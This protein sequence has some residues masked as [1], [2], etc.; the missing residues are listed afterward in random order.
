M[1]NV[2]EI[3]V[4]KLKESL[5]RHNNEKNTSYTVLNAPLDLLS[6]MIKLP[7]F[8]LNAINFENIKTALAAQQDEKAKSVLAEVTQIVELKLQQAEDHLSYWLM[9]VEPHKLINLIQY[10]EASKI[11]LTDLDI[12]LHE[13]LN[14]YRLYMDAGIETHQDLMDYIAHYQASHAK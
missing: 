11:D 2:T 5:F 14:K 6:K 7:T 10:C 3:T 4:G 9:D 12:K 13:M 8:I 1:S